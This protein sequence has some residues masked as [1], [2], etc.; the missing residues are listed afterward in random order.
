ML[1]G[2]VLSG[3]LTQT[4]GYY[5]MNFTFGALNPL[6]ALA[7]LLKRYFE[8]TINNSYNMC[9]GRHIMLSFSS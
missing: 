4:V 7:L 3:S 2:P 5:Y 1:I 9:G 8:L 6:N